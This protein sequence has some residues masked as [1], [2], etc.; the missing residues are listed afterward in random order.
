MPDYAMLALDIDGTL[1]G[2]DGELRPRTAEAV[3]RAAAAGIQPVLCTGRRYR[4]ALPV[5]RHLGLEVPWCFDIVLAKS[6][7]LSRVRSISTFNYS[8]RFDE[9]QWHCFA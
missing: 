6:V 4:R 9:A 7:D 5:A 3:A 1:M 2:R 8:H